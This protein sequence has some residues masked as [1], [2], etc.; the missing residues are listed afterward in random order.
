[1]SHL[2]RTSQIKQALNH[3]HYLKQHSTTTSYLSFLEDSFTQLKHSK[4]DPWE[5]AKLIAEHSLENAKLYIKNKLIPAF[6]TEL[7]RAW[8]VLH[9][10]NPQWESK[11]DWQL[12]RL[13]VFTYLADYYRRYHINRE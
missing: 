4:E 9:P 11:I 10:L 7:D 5:I 2:Q 1:M 12:L 6:Y 13:N 3:A 8:K